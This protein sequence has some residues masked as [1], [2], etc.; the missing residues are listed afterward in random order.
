MSARALHAAFA[1]VIGHGGL[2]PVGFDV[3]T[4]AKLTVH[5][6]LRVISLVFGS[7]SGVNVAIAA[8]ADVLAA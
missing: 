7:R 5:R 8:N 1:G 3:V 4:H 2:L 6:F